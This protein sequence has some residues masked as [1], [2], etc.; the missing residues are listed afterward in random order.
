MKRG[1][2]CERDVIFGALQKSA[3]SPAS[4]NGMPAE[5]TT[6]VEMLK[7]QGYAAACVGKWYLGCLPEFFPVNHGFDEW[8]GLPYS[9]DYWPVDYDGTKQPVGHS[10]C[11]NSDRLELGG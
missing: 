4:K 11:H 6:L 1:T 3:L 5:E 9:N 7:E 10:G 2:Q 8:L